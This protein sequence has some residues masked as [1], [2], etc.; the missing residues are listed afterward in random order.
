MNSKEYQ[1][2][3][4]KLLQADTEW[5]LGDWFADPVGRDLA[6][7]FLKEAHMARQQAYVQGQSDFALRVLEMI[8][9]FGLQRPVETLYTS[10]RAAPSEPFQRALLELAYGQ[11]LM[12]CKLPGAMEHLD[13]GFTLATDVLEAD[14]YFTLMKRHD[15]LRCLQPMTHPVEPQTLEV[16]LAEA[17]IIQ[18]ISG[19]RTGIKISGQKPDTL[20]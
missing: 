5:C 17:K 6:E 15:L 4:Q 18:C 11:L 1:S 2:P 3:A 13:A 19:P 8:A 16:L 7:V 12:S 20:G 10:L 9:T 14:V